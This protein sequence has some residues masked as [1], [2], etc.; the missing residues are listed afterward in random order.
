MDF[1]PLF[2]AIARQ[3][4]IDEIADPLQELIRSLFAGETGREVKN[5]LHGT[6]LGHPLHPVLTDIPVGAWTVAAVLDGLE[7]V[8]GNRQTGGVADA[9]IAIGLAGA[10]GSAITGFTDWSETEDRGRKVGVMHAL[11]NVVATT[12]YATSLVMRRS[13]KR[14]RSAIALSMMGYAISGSA[15]YLG[16]HLVFGEQIGIDHTATADNKKPE[17]FTAVIAASAFSPCP[18]P[19]LIWVV[20]YRK[21]S[22]SAM[23]FSVRG[24]SPSSGSK[25]VMW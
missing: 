10:V 16:G 14:R 25:T 19:V 8:S 6:W 5:A 4:W 11:L 7:L 22:S 13:R 1:E 21:G 3:P 2:N 15:A 18:I 23:R 24:I 9:A 12:L 17:K 20:L